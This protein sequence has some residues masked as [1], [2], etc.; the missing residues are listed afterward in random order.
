MASPD[1]EWVVEPCIQEESLIVA[2]PDHQHVR[3]ERHNF[4]IAGRYARPDV[5]K[6]IL[7]RKRQSRLSI[8]D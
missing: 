2:T 6:L 5:T 7:N 4:D 3:E 1:E 8:T